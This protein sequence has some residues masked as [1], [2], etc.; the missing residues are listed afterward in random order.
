MRIDNNGYVGIGTTTPAHPLQVAGTIG[1]EEVIVSSTGADYVFDDDYRLAPLSE[2]AAY[3]KD[4]HHLPDIPSAEEVKEKGV[5][6]GEMQTK[7]LAKVEELTLHMI[8]LEKENKEL[9]DRVERIGNE[10]K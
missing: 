7:L 4:N 9:R 1:A 6:L 3:V 5:S 2:V 10:A 8:E